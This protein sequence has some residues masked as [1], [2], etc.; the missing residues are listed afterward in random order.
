MVTRVPM[1]RHAWCA[2][3]RGTI[4]PVWRILCAQPRFWAR[5]RSPFWPCVVIPNRSTSFPNLVPAPGAKQ[6]PAAKTIP[7]LAERS[8]TAARAQWADARVGASR[9]EANLTV[10][11][12]VR[13]GGS[14]CSRVGDRR[15]WGGSPGRQRTPSPWSVRVTAQLQ[16]ASS[17]RPLR[18]APRTR[19]RTAR[20]VW[21]ARRA[22]KHF[23]SA[24]LSA[25]SAPR[26]SIASC[27]FQRATR[28]EPALGNATLTAI[29][30]TCRTGTTATGGSARNARIKTEACVARRNRCAQTRGFASSASATTSA[31]AATR[32]GRPAMCREG[33]ASSARRTLHASSPLKRRREACARTGSATA[34][35][36]ATAKIRP[37]APLASKTTAAAAARYNRVRTASSATRTVSASSSAHQSRTRIP[38]S[39]AARSARSSPAD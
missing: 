10:E 15:R 2:R 34:L 19:E 1:S 14:V 11:G 3:P 13:P 30:P 28:T 7:T 21:C 5:S 9:A 17:A 20:S 38:P 22:T 26:H 25:S 35:Q 16:A 31:Y 33:F 24:A 6:A 32:C 27:R 8:G 23:R 18:P 29:V 12:S 36:I 37:S 4:D 39:T